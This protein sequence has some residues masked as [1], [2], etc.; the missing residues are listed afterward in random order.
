MR[1]YNRIIYYFPQK[2]AV[3]VWSP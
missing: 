1:K 3:R 2:E